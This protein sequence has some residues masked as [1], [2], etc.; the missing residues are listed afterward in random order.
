MSSVW[1]PRPLLQARGVT[2]TYTQGQWPHRHRH[3]ALDCVNLIVRAGRTLA[4]MGGS[5]SGKSTLA[6]CLAALE[7]P[8]A[9]EVW[10]DGC[11]L[12]SADKRLVAKVRT[13]IQLVFQDSNSAISPTL[14]AE[15]IVGEPLLI[16]GIPRLHRRLLVTELLRQVGLSLDLKSRRANQLSGG[17]RQR[18]AVARALALQPRVLILDEPFTGLDLA[19]RGR[20]I[21][22]LLDLQQARAL[23]YLFVSHELDV[24]KHFSDDI[25]VIH[26]GS[27]VESGP[28][29]DV[30]RNPSHPATEALLTASTTIAQRRHPLEG[31]PACAI[32]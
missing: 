20:I 22:L 14:S 8:D 13:Q 29:A 4:L 15:E 21:N 18:L 27:I 26:G 7:T 31:E 12:V 32:C 17:Q 11:N 1:L 2:K 3:S 25:A 24:V 30:L 9:G 16:Q 19:A 5:G 6:L 23:T 10:F 28:T